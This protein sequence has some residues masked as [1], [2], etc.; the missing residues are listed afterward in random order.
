M[1][2]FTVTYKHG[3]HYCVEAEVSTH[4]KPFRFYF[5]GIDELGFLLLVSGLESE[6]VVDI[7]Q[8]A[9]AALFSGA[10]S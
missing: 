8:N 9:M 3:D 4:T 10:L 7:Q 1:T 2:L 6:V 5:R